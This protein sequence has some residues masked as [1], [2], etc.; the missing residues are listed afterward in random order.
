MNAIPTAIAAEIDANV[1]LPRKGEDYHPLRL[2]IYC[3][4]VLTYVRESGQTTHELQ[5]PAQYYPDLITI[6]GDDELILA[7]SRNQILLNRLPEAQP[8]WKTYVI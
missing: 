8:E 3:D 1:H 7:V 5:L 6:Y 2:E 4:D